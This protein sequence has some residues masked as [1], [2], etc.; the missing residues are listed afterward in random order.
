MAVDGIAAGRRGAR[1][2]VVML[3]D[4]DVSADSRVQKQARSAAEAGWDV[5]LLGKSP[6]AEEHTWLLGDATVRL[7][8]VSR[9]LSKPR[10]EFRRALLR[11]P[12]A[13]GPGRLAGYRRQL[14]KARRSD[15][16]QRRAVLAA[17][18]SARRSSWAVAWERL[19]LRPATVTNK[20]MRRWVDLRYRHT[21]SLRD[22]RATMGGPLDRFTTAFWLATMGDRAWR[23][24]DPHLWDY[25]IAFGKVIDG[26]APDLIHANDFRMLGVGARAALRGREGGRPVKLV[27]D[28]HEFLPGIKPW[29]AQHRWHPAQRAHEH[30]YAPFADAV[31][32]VSETL[33]DLLV[34]EHGL[35][36]HPTVVLNT[37]SAFAQ[38]PDAP[39]V[40]DLRG[41]C[42]I[43]SAVP[44]AVF[45]GAAAP[46]RGLDIMIESLPRVPGLHVALVVR[47][48]ESPYVAGLLA[49][50]TELGVAE[51][52]HVLPYVTHD[53]V[54]SF[55]SSA[56]IGV[57]P[58]HHWP[59]HEIALI[60]KFFEYS[61]ARLPIVVSDV[62]TMAAKT[63]ET[64]Q[65]EV[66][67]AEDID[68]YV[69]AVRAVLAD[70]A[71]YRDAYD[72]PGLLDGWTWEAQA[73]VLDGVYSRLLRDRLPDDQPERLDRSVDAGRT[74][75]A[76]ASV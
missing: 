63:R 36:A 32:T 48:P 15:L 41:L 7:L 53:Q 65:G 64:G 50:A 57:I 47:R 54:A 40:P 45:S 46:Q 2:M 70:P 72:A 39:P 5:V 17:G 28:A 61:H 73:A 27:W 9:A 13:Y 34:A 55:L 33:A 74:R 60:T 3:V 66:F 68:D 44:L 18:G 24:L 76:Q 69:R 22:A 14:V 58:I 4:N 11:R 37:P 19:L 56:D 25:E 6:D 51:R 62:K 20:V 75:S 31:V 8:A 21:E 71:R 67:R 42:G 1:G 43:G 29:V 49:T 16:Q 26:L 38:P 35:T 23:R 12:L 30:E 10:H 52:V 59:N